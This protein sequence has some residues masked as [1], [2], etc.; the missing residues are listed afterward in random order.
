MNSLSKPE[1][2]EEKPFWVISRSDIH[3]TPEEVGKGKWGV[4]RVAKYKGERVAARC[5][6]SR[7]M[8]EDNRQVMM[9]SMDVAAKMR[10]PNILPFIGAVLEGEPV[11]VTELMQTNL[12][13]VLEIGKLYNY[14]AASIALDVASA[15]LFLHTTRPEP[16]VHGDLTTTGVLLQKEVGNQWRAKLYDFMTAKFFRSVIMASENDLYRDGSFS[17]DNMSTSVFTS[18][19][20]A[21]TPRTTPPPLS[22]RSRKISGSETSLNRRLS[23][24]KISQ[25]APD[26]MD[27]ITLT[28]QR[29]VFSFGLLVV[30]MCTGTPPLGVSLQFLVESITWSEMSTMVK[31]C[32]EVEPSKRPTMDI[33]VKK[34]K[35]IHRAILARPSKHNVMQL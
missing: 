22:Y 28:E 30:E 7:I 4:V 24:R 10:H 2:T 1:R 25:T 23:S 29:D 16:I 17:P 15:L 12:K 3:F 8:S 20:R 6:Y 18:P 11:I 34:L 14:Q 5:L 35:G 32:T 21:M 26:M 33:V 27:S 9:E 19:T 31:M 13:K